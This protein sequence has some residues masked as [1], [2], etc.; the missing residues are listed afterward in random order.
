M[1]DYFER[2]L[3]IAIFAPAQERKIPGKQSLLTKCS[4]DD[5]DGNFSRFYAYLLLRM[6]MVR[7]GLPLA[8]SRCSNKMESTGLRKCPY[9]HYRTKKVMS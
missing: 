3:L 1:L 6:L 5:A 9:Y 8:V 4:L 7:P 2:K